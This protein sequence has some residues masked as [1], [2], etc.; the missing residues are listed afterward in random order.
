[1]LKRC[2]KRCIFISIILICN[3][4]FI[5]CEKSSTSNKSTN[6]VTLT[7]TISPTALPIITPTLISNLTPTIRPDLT[8]TTIPTTIPTKTPADED[9]QV[10]QTPIGTK[11]TYKDD[12][13]EVFINDKV[14]WK[15]YGDYRPAEANGKII[16]YKTTDGG[17]NWVEIANSDNVP[18]PLGIGIDAPMC[19]QSGI[20]FINDE[21]G[22]I[23]ADTPQE[24]YIG[25]Y[26]TSDGG[27]TWELQKLD[28]PKKSKTSTFGTVPP[29]FFSKND[30]ML[31]TMEYGSEASSPLVYVTHDGGVNWDTISEDSYDKDMKWKFSIANGWEVI[32]KKTIWLSQGR[33]DW[34]KKD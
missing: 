24:D 1:L 5:S 33:I 6:I 26:K 7:E 23:T 32:Y 12:G 27:Y 9:N 8:P 18:T 34:E 17:K 22:W 19:Y 10:Y 13:Y 16:L 11:I 3:I 4:V 2:L 29:V 14:G 25:L 30:G 28:I 20:T 15:H 31:F 21:I